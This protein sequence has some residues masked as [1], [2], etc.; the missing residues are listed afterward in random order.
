LAER[1]KQRRLKHYSSL[2]LIKHHL[3]V[4][5]TDQLIQQWNQEGLLVLDYEEIGGDFGLYELLSLIAAEPLSNIPVPPYDWIQRNVSWRGEDPQNQLHVDS[6]ASVIKLW[7]F[8][9]PLDQRHGPLRFVPGSHIHDLNRLYWLHVSANQPEA[10][11]EPS[12]RLNAS[13]PAADTIFASF[14]IQNVIP[15]LTLPNASSTLVIAD[16]SAIHARGIAQP[17]FVRHSLRLRGDNGGGVPRFDPF[18]WPEDEA[19]ATYSA[20]ASSSTSVSTKTPSSSLHYSSGS[21]SST[22]FSHFISSDEL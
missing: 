19:E 11:R 14:C 17:G 22:D 9:P 5:N 18:R 16:T 1:A 15:V 8:L 10:L 20:F 4:N 21:P 12:H 2:G 7:R 6:F 13:G 3:L